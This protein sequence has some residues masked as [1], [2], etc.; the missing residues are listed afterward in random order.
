MSQQ[1]NTYKSLDHYFM[2]NPSL[3]ATKKNQVKRIIGLLFA[4][5]FI[6]LAIFPELINFRGIGFQIIFGVIALVI[7]AIIFSG[8]L[9]SYFIKETGNKITSLKKKT[10]H[11]GTEDDMDTIIEA[12]NEDDFEAL[13]D[14]PS[15]DSGS[16]KIDIMHDKIGKECYL[17]LIN[18]YYGEIN[19][20][21][22]IKIFKGD[23]Y[24]EHYPVLRKL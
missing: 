22:E 10:F 14:I 4:A 20:T 12:Y 5:S 17:L 18:E 23:K 6:V 7:L 16:L 24:D 15:T 11:L 13:K 1:N 19:Y 9:D 3:F 8:L 2:A 21:S